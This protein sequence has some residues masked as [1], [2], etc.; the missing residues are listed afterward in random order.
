MQVLV[1]SLLFVLSLSLLTVRPAQAQYLGEQ[2]PGGYLS[3]IPCDASGVPLNPHPYPDYDGFYPMTGTQNLT[4]THT[5]SGE[6]VSAGLAA[7]PNGYQAE[8]LD[9]LYPIQMTAPNASPKPDPTH[10]YTGLGIYA[11]IDSA[12]EVDAG[13]SFGSYGSWW[14][15]LYNNGVPHIGPVNGSVTVAVTAGHLASYFKVTWYPSSSTAPAP[16][17]DHLN[18]L[19]RTNLTA[20]ASI[21]AGT[22]VHNNG[23]WAYATVSDGLPFGETASASA[24]RTGDGTLV[25][26]SGVPVVT[27]YH[28]V[29][30]AV[31][32]VTQIA[33]VS[34]DAALHYTANNDVPYGTLPDGTPQGGQVTNGPTSAHAASGVSAGVQPDDREVT[35]HRDGAVYETVDAAGVTHGDTVYS[36]DNISTSIFGQRQVDPHIIKHTFHPTFTGDWF[37]KDND[38]F[39]LPD[40]IPWLD[41]WSWT[42]NH[43]DDDEMTGYWTMPYGNLEF[44]LSSG[45]VG[46]ITGP[47]TQPL[48]YTATALKLS[49]AGVGTADGATAAATY[50]MTIHDAVEG[51]ADATVSVEATPTPYWGS[52]PVA[53]NPNGVLYLPGEIKPQDNQVPS[54]SVVA[55]TSKGFSG[56]G[57]ADI[58]L[59]KWTKLFNVNFSFGGEIS[60]TSGVQTSFPVNVYVGP[61]QFTY[62]LFVHVYNRHTFTWRHYTEAGE[63]KLFDS[64]NNE[65]LHRDVEDEIAGGYITYATPLP[66][67]TPIPTYESTP[68]PTTP[69]P[70]PG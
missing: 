2:F 23:L 69:D 28:L 58:D 44:D 4:I 56:Q 30:A 61:N 57:G 52:F 33:T 38:P 36:Y 70:G 19:L 46:S 42:P 13:N 32:P 9:P 45:W 50:S 21:N 6:M 68:T 15:T 41:A 31:N 67:G 43:S 22:S 60:H 53:G 27:G 24:G 25:G 48:I 65:K 35:I 54:L 64:N 40:Q 12:H 14:Y 26:S 5:Y 1:L 16:M 66:I 7:W 10:L 62:P 20:E 63:H 11:G 51:L 34:L 8:W 3:A 55:E 39:S 47:T 17:P 59:A 37:M 18:L 49:G 29:R